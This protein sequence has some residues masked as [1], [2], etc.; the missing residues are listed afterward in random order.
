LADAAAAAAAAAALDAP[1]LLVKKGAVPAD[2][3]NALSDLGITRTYLAG[4]PLSVSATVQQA[5]P[6]AV[7]LYGGN[8]YTTATAVAGAARILG[9]DSHRT[10]IT[11]GDMTTDAVTVGATGRLLVLSRTDGLP[12]S[13]ETFL[14]SYAARATLVGG[15]TSL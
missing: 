15:R 9:A 2:V 6:S 10:F 14:T 11:R 12:S 5:L 13:T 7:R 3:A 4:G 1:L 8:R